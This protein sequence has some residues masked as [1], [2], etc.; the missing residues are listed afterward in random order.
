[1]HQISS[2]LRYPGGK[3]VLTN[4]LSELIKLNKLHDST[5]V[6]PYAG[7]AGAALNLLYKE[8][9]PKIIIND[10]DPLIYA[11]WYSVINETEAFCKK[12]MNSKIS[13]N[14]WERKKKIIKDIKN[15]SLLDVGFAA[16]Y[17][18]R[19]NRSGII[20]GG[21]I[22]GKHQI[23]K[24]KLD[25]R[26]NKKSLI[27]RIN[28]IAYYKERIE[29]SNLD[30]IKLMSF[31]KKRKTEKKFYFLDPPYYDKGSDLYLNYYRPN[32]HQ[33]LSKHLDAVSDEKWVL[34]YD[35]VKEISSL[36]H[37][38]RSIYYDINYSAGSTRKGDEIIIFSDS[39]LI[40]KAKILL[41]K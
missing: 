37:R 12:I 41:S 9:V 20:N 36:Y 40:P 18:N 7:G 13:I 10:A 8:F 33:E 17:L 15:Q 31:L 29:I 14:V 2:P 3:S 38:R 6:E 24:W 34:T 39:I 27:D 28:K 1:M 30:A 16:F 5:Y 22:G 11:F 23:G 35:N 26:F 25:A 32:D 21:P 19:T 4:Y